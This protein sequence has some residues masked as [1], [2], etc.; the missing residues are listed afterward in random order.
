MVTRNATKRRLETAIYRSVIEEAAEG[1][2]VA[3]LADSALSPLWLSQAELESGNWP[4]PE[5]YEAAVLRIMAEITVHHQYE[6]SGAQLRAALIRGAERAERLVVEGT[7]SVSKEPTVP[8]LIAR[9]GRRFNW[10]HYNV[11]K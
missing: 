8:N 3:L 2:A 10:L 5:A 7:A 11:P 1:F 6:L 9:T 4:I